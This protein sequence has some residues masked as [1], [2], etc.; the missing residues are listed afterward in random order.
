MIYRFGGFVMVSA[1]LPLL[2]AVSAGAAPVEEWNK[3]F[4]VADDERAWTALQTS[5]NGYI[6]ANWKSFKGTDRGNVWLIKTDSK[7]NELWNKVIGESILD[8]PISM[9]YVLEQQSFEL[10]EFTSSGP[11]TTEE[12]IE[13]F[14]KRRDQLR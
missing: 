13:F 4:G 3:T 2:L 1:V 10:M 8:I 5:D 7:G 11:H 9:Q 6:L 12:T 14:K